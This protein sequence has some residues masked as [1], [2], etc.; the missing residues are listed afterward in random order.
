[1]IGTG[2]GR[3]LGLCQALHISNCGPV[4]E[5]APESQT[6]A[7]SGGPAPD[8]LTDLAMKDLPPSAR[9]AAGQLP[10]VDLLAA[11]AKGAPNVVTLSVVRT[12]TQGA[13]ELDD[14]YVGMHLKLAQQLLYGH[15]TPKVT[16][17]VLQLHRTEDMDLVR[18]RLESLFTAGRLPLD[19]RDYGERN[20]YV[21]QVIGIF[22]FI[23]VF[24]AVIIGIVV[25]F[26]VTNTVGMAIVE[27]TAEIGTVR[28]LGLRRWGIRQQFLTEGFLLGLIGATAGV[29]IATVIVY[30]VNHSG[31]T[32]TPPG[33]SKPTEFRLD[34][35]TKPIL[36]IATWVLLVIVAAVSAFLPA[37]RAARLPVVD[38]L[39]HV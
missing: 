27:R 22:F 24:I 34:L 30:A 38:A 32:W 8:L 29:V 12:A 21:M 4:E 3:M 13:K 5:F 18:R 6:P 33:D 31:L 7:G 17:I 10:H 15:G 11:T 28:A 2:M 20:P 23:F 16:G 19:V 37:N 39:R 35:F 9:S 1:V 26:T 14:N 25:L 36:V